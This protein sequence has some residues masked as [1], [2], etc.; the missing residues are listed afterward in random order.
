MNIN[1]KIRGAK[2]VEID[3]ILF[4]SRLEANCYLL[5]KESGLAFSYETEK[6]ILSAPFKPNI[7]VLLSSKKESNKLEK[8]KNT[9]REISYTPDF[10]IISPS[11]LKCIVEIK[12]YANDVYPLKKKL[13]I[14]KIEEIDSGSGSI[15]FAEIR[16]LGQF[17]DLINYIK[18]HNNA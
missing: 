2:S 9:I 6:L 10:V 11:G 3:N 7:V 8:L 13:I 17:Q 15:V 18:T 5:L 1:K 12:G 4:R 14:K 16:N